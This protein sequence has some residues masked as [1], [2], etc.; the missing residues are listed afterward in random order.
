MDYYQVL[1]ISR[2]ASKEEI[3]KAFKK[4]ARENHPDAKPDDA[5]A[6]EK[7]KQAAE[8]YDVLGDEEKRKK[9]DQYGE[10]WK[11]V[12]GGGG[13]PGGGSPFRSGGPVDVDLRDIFGGDGAVDLQDLFGGMFGGGGGGRRRPQPRRG[14]DLKTSI[15]VPFEL[16]A[17]GGNY[18]LTLSREGTAERIS[19]KIPAGIESG[20]SIRLAGQ[21]GAGFQGGSPGDVLVTVNVA[22]HPY[23]RREGNDLVLEVPVSVSEAIL[24]AKIDVPTLDEGLVTLTLPPGTSSGAKLRLKGKGFKNLKTK[25]VG[26]EFIIIKIQVPKEIDEQSKELLEQFT[27][28]NPL[29]P[30]Y[31]MW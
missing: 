1:G 6:S 12:S 16:A 21:G 29:S 9:Y 26:D 18:D 24:G 11:H 4:I 17:R 30:R 7:F 10:N 5:V 14:Q 25:A 28:L 3:R 15:L 23:F 13:A 8:A 20:K 2:G 31:G 22:S 19:I 27:S